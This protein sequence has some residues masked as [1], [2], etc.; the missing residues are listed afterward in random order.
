MSLLPVEDPQKVNTEQE[1]IA[2]PSPLPGAPRPQNK[3]GNGGVA[4][5]K[6]PNHAVP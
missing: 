2:Y 3:R 5:L 1:R 6:G 4:P